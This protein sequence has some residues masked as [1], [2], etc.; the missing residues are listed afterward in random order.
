MVMA[1]SNTMAVPRSPPLYDAKENAPMTPAAAWRRPGPGSSTGS[2]MRDRGNGA[3]ASGGNMVANGNEN[4]L[5]DQGEQELDRVLVGVR[6]RPLVDVEKEMSEKVSWRWDMQQMESEEIDFTSLSDKELAHLPDGRKSKFAF[7]RV[8]APDEQTVEVYVDQVAGMVE[9]VVEGYNATVLAYGQTTS[10][11]THTITGSEQEKGILQLALE[12]LFSLVHK[13]GFDKAYR[14]SLHASYCEI[15]QEVVRDL[16]DPAKHHLSI[17]E[18]PQRG[19]IVRGLTEIAINS[20]EQA[21]ELVSR[22]QESRKV[23]VTHISESSSRSHSIFQIR[24]ES[25][26][27]LEDAMTIGASY[28]LEQHL[29]GDTQGDEN[30]LDS[31]AEGALRRWADTYEKPLATS[32]LNIIDLAGSE[33]VSKTRAS[34]ERLKE[35]GF[36]NKSLA[37][38][39]NVISAINAGS[40]HIPFR[41][42]KLTR[43]LTSA[44]GG[45][46]YTAMICCV[47][48]SILHHDETR[49]TL[50]FAHR[51]SKVKTHAK[52]NQVE[53]GDRILQAFRAQVGTLQRELALNLTEKQSLQD[54]VEELERK[55]HN[56][57]AR[58]LQTPRFDRRRSLIPQTATRAQRPRS[59]SIAVPPAP[60]TAARLQ[61]TVRF[62][63]ESKALPDILGLS[64]V[65]QI[66][67]DA[68]ETELIQR[69]EKVAAAKAYLLNARE[70]L[71]AFLSRSPHELL[72]VSSPLL[73]DVDELDDL[74]FELEEAK[75]TL[76]ARESEFNR[77]LEE[78]NARISA[79]EQQLKAANEATLTAMHE[80]KEL[81]SAQTASSNQE[82]QIT[83]ELQTRISHLEN[84]LQREKNSSTEA[85]KQFQAKIAD[86]EF[87]LTQR[88]DELGKAQVHSQGLDSALQTKSNELK[89]QSSKADSL[90]AE[91]SRMCQEASE[92]LGPIFSTVTSL[93]AEESGTQTNPIEN[94][95]N[96]RPTT[97]SNGQNYTKD[98]VQS[99]TMLREKL[100]Q[101]G[102]VD[103]KRRED[104][105]MMNIS[106]SNSNEE[107]S[108]MQD[109]MEH[110]AAETESSINRIE[111]LQQE[112]QA[113]IEKGVNLES[114]VSDLKV[115]IEALDNANA[116]LDK[117]LQ[118]AKSS[119]LVL[120]ESQTSDSSAKADLQRQVDTLKMQLQ[121][122]EEQQTKLNRKIAEKET[123]LERMTSL[124]A[125]LEQLRTVV[126][127][128]ENEKQDLQ[129]RAEDAE[130]NAERTRELED[131]LEIR[132]TRVTELEN[133]IK[134]K[135]SQIAIH[136]SQI[137][138]A[139]GDATDLQI[140]LS[141]IEK[142]NQD[143]RT[144]NEEK[145]DELESLQSSCDSLRNQLKNLQA[146][147]E[148]YEKLSRECDILRKIDQEEKLKIS[149]LEKATLF[150][151]NQVNDLETL[152]KEQQQHANSKLQT[153]LS[154][155]ENL[156]TENES[157]KEKVR[158]KDAT[159]LELLQRHEKATLDSDANVLTLTKD[160]TTLR[161]ERDALRGEK[162]ELQIKL[163]E[164][165][166]ELKAV[167]GER[168]KL[169]EKLVDVN[170]TL[171]GAE[172][173]H[174]SL[175]SEHERR[176]I[177][178]QAELDRTK[179]KVEGL[180]QSLGQSKECF[181]SMSKEKTALD[182]EV[183]SLRNALAESLQTQERL[184]ESL[185][186]S[187]QSELV[188]REQ[189]ES[190][191]KDVE[192]QKDE[193]RRRYTDLVAMERDLTGHGEIDQKGTETYSVEWSQKRIARLESDYNA[194]TDA[195]GEAK[196]TLNRLKMENEK[197]HRALS[198]SR[199]QT[200][201][202]TCMAILHRQACRAH[203]IAIDRAG[204]KHK[205]AA[206]RYQ[207]QIDAAEAQATRHAAECKSLTS[208]IQHSGNGSAEFSQLKDSMNE[209]QNALADRDKE[210][211]KL[212]ALLAQAEQTQEDFK[213]TQ[214]ELQKRFDSANSEKAIAT[215]ARQQ[216]QFELAR[217]K[218]MQNS[219]EA[220]VARQEVD[221]A[222]MAICRALDYIVGHGAA[223]PHLGVVE[224]VNLLDNAT[225]RMSKEEP[226][227]A[228]S[229]NVDQL[230]E[231]NSRLQTS[232]EFLQE[233][234]QALESENQVL[235]K[236]LHEARKQPSGE[237]VRVTSS[238]RKS[239]LHARSIQKLESKLDHL[240]RV[241]Q[242]KD[243]QMMEYQQ[244]TSEISKLLSQKE[245]E[246]EACN[247]KIKAARRAEAKAQADLAQF[248]A[249]L[250]SVEANLLTTPSSRRNQDDSI[251]RRGSKS[252]PSTP[253][254]KH[255]SDSGKELQT[256]QE[257]HEVLQGEFDALVQ[258]NRA[259]KSELRI[260]E[261]L[262][263][264]GL[265]RLEEEGKTIPFSSGTSLSTVKESIHRY[266]NE[267]NELG[268]NSVN[269]N[270]NV[271]ASPF[272]AFETPI[273]T[274]RGLFTTPGTSE[275]RTSTSLI[276][277]L[278]QSAS[279]QID[280]LK[281]GNHD[282]RLAFIE[283]ERQLSLVI[284][285]MEE[286]E[287]DFRQLLDLLERF[288]HNSED[289]AA[290]L[291][292]V[293]AHMERLLHWQNKKR[294][295]RR[296][297]RQKQLKSPTPTKV[298]QTTILG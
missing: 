158:T 214:A 157:F 222:S 167:T 95:V 73:E 290:Q 58:S 59:L 43:L 172:E 108:G 127:A 206:K 201:L 203:R 63:D 38:L 45:N 3:G 155:L 218:S 199:R 233:R 292:K 125:E 262:A 174:A 149:E 122:A 76:S 251:D 115:K 129:T 213:K 191:H 19:P 256:L 138:K 161:S 93:A 126:S 134:E 119:I 67:V 2:N 217:V 17:A 33:R 37:A 229:A 51:A 200:A 42:S 212:K 294:E 293:K 252:R 186:A 226:D 289:Y 11:K 298:S 162:D 276:E 188:A 189:A 69:D 209:L 123:F 139:T 52:L 286:S 135:D 35:A 297:A 253:K 181:Q 92:L 6:V 86:L 105:H 238:L 80:A 236:Q 255:P 183:K 68:L 196:T 271:I 121:T 165:S 79:L 273:A 220:K 90:E 103:A 241:L 263:Q 243:I 65:S 151:Q 131:T 66:D 187:R 114:T 4:T 36:I 240:E 96:K 82:R 145:E 64:V 54:K 15:Y 235:R 246:I 227:R 168:D 211:V 237:D 193:L 230:N 154:D 107:I 94:Q 166:D 31:S 78:S 110:L 141:K 97:P 116:L 249:R 280:A 102:E 118:E 148:D 104:L 295:Q 179:L 197:L 159:N 112:K 281:A 204:R 216:L 99:L 85:S 270:M 244:E 272:A 260:A 61:P 91:M 152:N 163:N 23:G 84:D 34:G 41:S 207:A 124:E 205:A 279:R 77:S 89:M 192:K 13:D 225:K 75:H 147:V 70:K 250:A 117:Q 231:S 239:S 177:L 150:L 62:Q 39:G 48:P 9:R 146:Q 156:R 242:E 53:T 21:L 175:I 10:G 278:R 185:D 160:L 71:Q 113:L 133:E 182:E 74:R 40:S 55:L 100:N 245:R 254:S 5:D 44:L 259:L 111:T 195:L 215:D 248:Q 109:K 26:P 190:T 120:R 247:D 132:N 184:Q 266:E 16:L 1:Q 224:L 269:T 171:N 137:K 282:L 60:Y 257:A 264:E 20:A 101:A 291:V 221:L 14:F 143:L 32:T 49:S 219:D 12:D 57:L 275:S 8:F 194:A 283:K 267:R 27:R 144:A 180:E 81:Q 287:S 130:A 28:S 128:V 50:Q 169:E 142:E 274:R 18:D 284:G 164:M 258:E 285:L 170:E 22:G 176:S 46:S 234:V 265:D 178:A 202:G 210:I 47:S 208:F 30:H 288:N 173:K 198:R 25:R 56:N 72:N 98:I 140:T 261:D 83:Q 7:D 24:V 223:S 106:L 88:Q 29:N 153:A 296:L 136:L 87:A 277:E 232:V 228:Y 268:Q